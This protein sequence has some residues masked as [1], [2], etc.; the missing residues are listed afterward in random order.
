MAEE[1]KKPLP[2]L[3]AI[4]A[5]GDA[6]PSAAKPEGSAPPKKPAAAPPKAAPKK[7]PQI[8]QPAT[9]SPTKKSSGVFRNTP[10][11]PPKAPSPSAKA[12]MAGLAAGQGNLK[13]GKIPPPS[14]KPKTDPPSVARSRPSPRPSQRLESAPSSS[15]GRRSSEYRPKT[16]ETRPETPQLPPPDLGLRLHKSGKYQVIVDRERLCLAFQ[17]LSCKYG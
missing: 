10:S 1:A 13:K 17:R 5:R 4:R 14:L 11:S 15:R 8:T 12:L 3:D 2:F 16:P 7:P 6:P 9:P